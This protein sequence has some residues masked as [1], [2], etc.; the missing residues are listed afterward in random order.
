ML[1][2]I[3]ALGANLEAHV[4]L[5][6]AITTLHLC[7]RFGGKRVPLTRLPVE[8][9]N[10]I[11]DI[12]MEDECEKS[13]QE[14]RQD[15]PCFQQDCEFLDRYSEEALGEIRAEIQN[16]GCGCESSVS[17]TEYLQYDDIDFEVHQDRFDSWKERVER[18]SD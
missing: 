14:W 6:P 8:L 10:S 13:R 18:L 12:L 7:H 11:E 16:C 15:Y 5:R 1:V 2:D 4:N 17:L 3:E 9:L